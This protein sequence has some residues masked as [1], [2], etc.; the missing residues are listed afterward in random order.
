MDQKEFFDRQMRERFRG[1]KPEPP[2]DAWFAIMQGMKPVANKRGVP[3]WFRM[4]AAVAVLAVAGFSLWL[5]PRFDGDA[6][7]LAG[8][9][10]PGENYRDAY[11][12]VG[13][14]DHAPSLLPGPAADYTIASQRQAY[15]TAQAEPVITFGLASGSQQKLSSIP[16]QV[17][18]MGY[19][20]IYTYQGHRT[21][22]LA[23][24]QHNQQFFETSATPDRYPEIVVGAHMVTQYSYRQILSRGDFGS[25]FIP[26]ENLE[27][28]LFT[29]S[30]GLSVSLRM[31]DR[32]AFQTGINYLNMGQYVSDIMSFSSNDQLPLFDV[33]RM[34]D[35]NHP[36]TIITSQGSIRLSEPT[37]YFAD[38]QSFR[39]LTN[40]QYL[41]GQSPKSLSQRER[42]IS[43]YYRFIEVPVLMQVKLFEQNM[44]LHLKAGMSGTYM[45]HNGVYLGTDL[46]QHSIGETIGLRNFN[47]SAIGGLMMTIPVWDRLHLRVEPTAQMFLQPLVR[48]DLT[49]GRAI[50]YNFSLF[51]GFT[52]GF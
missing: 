33:N 45:L 30:Y 50:P 10:V 22:P 38:A 3:L 16:A 28:P 52:Y 8:M 42:G 18:G 11:Q 35:F 15:P 13:A 37:L 41:D 36:Q 21:L 47:F 5:L 48:D 1:Y 24:A 19:S 32:W 14:P 7:G 2:P 29:M 44:G 40:K 51:T 25:G 12:A 49:G 43:Q 4:A 39:V 23:I 6:A 20:S 34:L 27:D 31:S 17:T 46:M 9:H 26:F